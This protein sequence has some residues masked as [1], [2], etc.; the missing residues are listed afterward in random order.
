MIFIVRK[1]PTVWEGISDRA[2]PSSIRITKY[3]E[4]RNDYALH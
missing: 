1:M 2:L 3:Y 4:M